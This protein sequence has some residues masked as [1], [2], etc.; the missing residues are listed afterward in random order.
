MNAYISDKICRV[1]CYCNGWFS[2]SLVL[3]R[4]YRSNYAYIYVSFCVS[5][6]IHERKVS[7]RCE[8]F[9]SGSEK[10]VLYASFLANTRQLISM[11]FI[12]IKRSSCKTSQEDTTVNSVVSMLGEL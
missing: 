2:L 11:L 3:P 7:I 12:T 8:I 6:V 5:I 10:W 4:I 1:V 9:L